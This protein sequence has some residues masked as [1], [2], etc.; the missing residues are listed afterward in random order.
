MNIVCI[1]DSWTWGAELWD[2]TISTEEE[3]IKIYGHDFT[4]KCMENHAY[5]DAHRWTTILSH[6]D[7]YE[8]ENLG[9]SGAS[10]RQI[11]EALHDR[12]TLDTNIDIIVLVWTSQFRASIRS[13]NWEL[14][15]IPQ[16]R[17]ISVTRPFADE[18]FVDI[19]YNELCTAHWLAKDIPIINVNAFYDN[20]VYNNVDRMIF[21]DRTLLDVATEGKIKDISSSDWHWHANSMH[22]LIDFNL[23]RQGH[24]DENGHKL[25]AKYIDAKIKE[26]K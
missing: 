25:I 21:A 16:D 7:D 1:G 17:F 6:S 9:Q 26:Y 8:V 22:D 19:F 23:K 3:A 20:K 11:L 14:K 10:N 18:E 15:T 5:V 4:V 13:E 24:P 12:L 2:R